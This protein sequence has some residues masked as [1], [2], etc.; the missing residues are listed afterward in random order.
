MDSMNRWIKNELKENF[1]SK[2]EYLI[3]LFEN[4]AN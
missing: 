3:N 4:E 2:K 1:N